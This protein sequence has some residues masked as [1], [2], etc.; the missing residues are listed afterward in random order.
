MG[1]DPKYKHYLNSSIN[2]L[3]KRFRLTTY[4]N[5]FGLSVGFGSFLIAMMFVIDEFSYDK[6][7]NRSNDIFRVVVNWTGDGVSRNWARSSPP[8]GQLLHEQIPDIEKTV[9]IR[10]NSGTDLLEHGDRK[11]YEENLVFADSTFFEIFNFEL[12]TG[13]ASTILNDKYS[14]VISEKIA[15]KYFPNKDPI[16]EL[17]KYDRRFDLAVSGVM[18]NAP[19]NTH[20]QFDC[21]IPFNLL[22]EI[23]SEERL[24]HWGQ[25]DHYP[26]HCLQALAFYRL[27]RNSGNA[28][29]LC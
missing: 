11:F 18:K 17:L 20:L 23:F 25:F 3:F 12:V 8:I 27:P 29:L 9:R 5:I 6:F 7:H 24:S 1:L 13:D 4:I 10:K 14:I 15:E 2:F 19:A 28:Q 21:I 22:E 26:C 16:G